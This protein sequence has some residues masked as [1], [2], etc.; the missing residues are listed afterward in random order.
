MVARKARVCLQAFTMPSKNFLG[1]VVAPASL[2]LPGPATLQNRPLQN[3]S[4]SLVVVQKFWPSH[5]WPAH[6]LWRWARI[7]QELLAEQGDLPR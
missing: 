6:W 1:D 7:V 2:L 4:R 3:R 5:F